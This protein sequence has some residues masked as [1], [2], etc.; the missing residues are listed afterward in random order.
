MANCKGCNQAITWIKT[1][2]G[3]AHPVNHGPKKLWVF[4]SDGKWHLLDCYESHFA[5]CPAADKFRNKKE[6]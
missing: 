2:S 6:V 3:K 5:N 1:E 4:L